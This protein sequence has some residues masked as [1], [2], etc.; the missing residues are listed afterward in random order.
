MDII[1][2]LL[3]SFHFITALE[4]SKDFLMLVTCLE[5]T[6]ILQLHTTIY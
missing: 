5:A 3:L 4:H 6:Q 1:L 2:L